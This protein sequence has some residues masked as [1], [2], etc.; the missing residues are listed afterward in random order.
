MDYSTRDW[1]GGVRL[2]RR[3]A[4]ATGNQRPDSLVDSNQGDPGEEGRCHEATRI[5]LHRTVLGTGGL[6]SDGTGPRCRPRDH[7]PRRGRLVTRETG[8]ARRICGFGRVHGHRPGPGR[9]GVLLMGRGYEEL[10]EPLHPQ[11]AAERSLRILRRRRD[12]RSG[13][14]DGGTRHR[15]Q[16]DRNVHK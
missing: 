4:P 5:A 1:R 9:Q 3:L 15:R 7:H 11:A 14:D 2:D 6:R 10:P 13:S 8:R 12:R 16:H